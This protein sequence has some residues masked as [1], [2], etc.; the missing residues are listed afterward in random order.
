MTPLRL[1]SPDALPV[2]FVSRLAMQEALFRECGSLE[3]VLEHSAVRAI[4]D[5]LEAHLTQQR[6]HGYHC[7]KEPEPGYF[8]AQGLRPTDVGRHQDEFLAMFGARFTEAEVAEMKAAWHEY[9]VRSGQSRHRNGLVWV[10]LSRSLV[11]TSGTQAFYR[12]FGGEAIYMPF[13]ED[14]SVAAKLA[15]IGQ[16]VVVEVS[17]PGDAL[18]AGYPMAMAVLSQHHRSVRPNA[19]LYESEARLRQGVPA[20][21]VIRVTPLREFAP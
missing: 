16:P 20:T 4:A 11:K 6:I 5:D 2:R 17:L 10:C 9:F 12:Y 18:K 21:D 13:Q 15:A 7:T 19:Q 3:Q 14:S 1:E 8:A